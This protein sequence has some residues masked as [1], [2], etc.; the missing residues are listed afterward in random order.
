M[1]TLPTPPRAAAQQHSGWAVAWATLT[2]VRHQISEDCPDFHFSK[3]IGGLAVAVADGVGGGARGDIAAQTL[4]R[5]CVSVPAALL[6]E[7]AGLAQWLRLAE[8][9]VQARLREVTFSPGAATLAAAWLTDDGAGWV[10]HI[11]DC[12]L[13]HCQ[14]GQILALTQDHSYAATGETPPPGVPASAPARMVGTGCMG[15]PKLRRIALMPG[16]SLLL[17][18]DGLHGVLDAPRIAELL[19]QHGGDA[20]AACIALAQ[21]AR[22]AGGEDDITVLLVRRCAATAWW[23]RWG[24]C[25]DNW[26]T[27]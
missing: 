12:R 26:A 8:A 18:S 7:R 10:T 9:Q 19:A 13:Y 1:P 3:K 4:A 25:V 5:H 14:P 20:Q 2:G 15:E 17:C 11:G 23:R 21:A 27:H 6:G 24:A 16:E 22:A